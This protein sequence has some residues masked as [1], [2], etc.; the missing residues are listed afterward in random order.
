MNVRYYC[1]SWV[2]TATFLNSLHCHKY[3][4]CPVTTKPASFEFLL[5]ETFDPQTFLHY[6]SGC[7]HAY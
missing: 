5:E 2:A 4:P 3:L 7:V 6:V 1:E